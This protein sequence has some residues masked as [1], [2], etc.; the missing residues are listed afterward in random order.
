MKKWAWLVLL[1]PIG[2][3]LPNLNRFTFPVLSNYSDLLITHW[4]NANFIHQEILL[5]HSLPLWNDSIL[6]GY[7]FF[8]N[9]LSG[10]WYLPGWFA[11][12][13]PT[14]SAFNLLFLAHIF[15]GSLGIYLILKDEKLPIELALLGAIAFEMM[16]KLWA[17]FGQGHVSLVYAVCLTPWLLLL[18]RRAF[19]SKPGNIYRFLPAFLI[20]GI[21][22]ADPRWI[23]YAM[24]IWIMD[25]GNYFRKIPT[26]PARKSR[27]WLLFFLSNIGLGI[28]MASILIL[29]MAQYTQL[30]TR[31]LMTLQ[32]TLAFSLPILKIPLILY[33]SPGITAEWVF[34]LGGLGFICVLLAVLNR[35]IRS[36]SM[37]WL[38]I[39]FLGIVIAI[40]GSI[41]VL[42]Q[43]W[44]LPGLSLIRVPSRALFLSGFAACFLISHVIQE[45]FQRT[46]NKKTTNLALAACIAIGGLI[47]L[48]TVMTG[49]T[50]NLVG[51]IQG[52][53][54]LLI[55]ALILFFIL[56]RDFQTTWVWLIVGFL[57][58]DFSLLN[59]QS[60]KFVDQV[61]AFTQGKSYLKFIQSNPI[62]TTRIFTPSNSLPQQTASLA[63]IEMVNGI[64]PLQL[65]SLNHF[66]PFWTSSG[67]ILDGYSVTFPPFLTGNPDSD[68]SEMVLD[69]D[70]LGFL[71]VKYVL[72][73]FP[74][75]NSKLLP[76]E[77]TGE[78]YIYENLDFRPRAW[79]QSASDPIGK[80]IQETPYIQKS[81]NEI[82]LITNQPGMLVL[83]E[84]FYTGWK[85]SIDGDPIPIQQQEGLL[86]SVIVPEGN[87]QVIFTFQPDIFW[88]SLIITLFTCLGLILMVIIEFR[89]SHDRP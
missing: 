45:I 50:L 66:L 13:F 89:E 12:L 21:A 53:I 78:G 22:I 40:S 58:L 83:S 81:A 55:F 87:H 43:L 59:F 73:K 37:I 15:A 56:N 54:S 28:L 70:K 3:Y 5:H 34:Y 49:T 33:P 24:L 76:V 61:V 30:S 86:R 84:V 82:K 47:P 41:P 64:D 17:H 6:A 16:P 39:F 71:N 75:E 10:L 63:G 72:S 29:P 38:I 9:P 67:K 26:P 36:A 65:K 60:F 74:I 68:N 46:V 79:I 25:Y 52:S 48:F 20:A 69:T 1:I 88:I 4:P 44:R 2:L 51:V 62:D 80:N 57:L 11:N 14:A 85:A 35:K 31:S 27:H 18:T 23:P 19:L 77:Q 42:S 32:D 8:A 7:P